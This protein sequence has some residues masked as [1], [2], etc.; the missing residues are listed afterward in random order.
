MPLGVEQVLMINVISLQLPLAA[1]LRCPLGV[2]HHTL[3]SKFGLLRRRK[4]NLEAP[5]TLKGITGKADLAVT[6]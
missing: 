3:T 6:P 2:K 1:I 5:S 4:P